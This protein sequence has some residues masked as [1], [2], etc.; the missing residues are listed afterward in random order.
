VIS[1]TMICISPLLPKFLNISF[2]VAIRKL[3][4]F[5]MIKKRCPEADD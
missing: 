5:A 2:T 1:T 4:V 3:V